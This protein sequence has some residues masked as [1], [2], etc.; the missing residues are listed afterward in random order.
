MLGEIYSMNKIK[1]NLADLSFLL[2]IPILGAI[3]PILN[4]P[5]NGA[6]SLVTE[7]DKAIP[8]VEA[9]II[10][11]IL[12]YPFV[13]LCLVYFCFKDKKAYFRTLISISIGML[14]SYF[15]FF[16][17][18]TH[19][20]RPALQGNDIF[21]RLVALIYSRDNPYNCFPSLHV[22]ESYLMIKGIYACSERNKLATAFI[23]FMA[24]A[25]IL[26]TLFV[27]QHVILDVFGAVYL[28]EVV[29]NRVPGFD[30]LLVYLKR[31]K[32]HYT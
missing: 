6:K 30:S 11:Y 15:I 24:A 7:V 29:F 3:Y 26:S 31:Q 5:A 10:P 12:W 9:F 17:F 14:I 32:P 23:N 13:F 20:P 21:T 22:L 18:Q 27:K 16:V 28:G 1:E 4:N 2:I 25:I 19:V 8:L